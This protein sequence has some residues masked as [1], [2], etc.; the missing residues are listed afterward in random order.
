MGCHRHSL[1]HSLSHLLVYL[2]YPQWNTPTL[3]FY[4]NSVWIFVNPSRGC[5]LLLVTTT[6]FCCESLCLGSLVVT[7][8]ESRF[9]M[10]MRSP[11]YRPRI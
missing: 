7:L 8:F 10:P 1:I 9:A 4:A 2:L 6:C 3:C 11:P 5:L